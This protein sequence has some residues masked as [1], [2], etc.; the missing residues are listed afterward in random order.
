MEGIIRVERLFG[1]SGAECS[2]DKAG[3]EESDFIV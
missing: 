1:V 3:E 2:R